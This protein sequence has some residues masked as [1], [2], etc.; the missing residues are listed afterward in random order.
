MKLYVT[1]HGH[2]NYNRLGI[3]SSDPNKNVHLTRKGHRQARELAEKLKDAPLDRIFIT[4]LK[5][6]RQTAE[7]I[8]QYHGLGL[9]VDDRLTEINTGYE[10]I[11]HIVWKAALMQSKDPLHRRFNGG[12]SLVDT[13]Q[14]IFDFMDE[15]VKKYP[16]DTILIVTHANTAQVIKGYAS[17]AALN[18]IFKG[19][20]KNGEILEF[21]L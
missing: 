21:D 18:E 11:Q 4:S 15:L 2:T 3:L 7:H 6:T 10:G 5:R 13:K 14:R 9:T 19:T 12:E 1:R 16:N 17:K 8:N 20:V